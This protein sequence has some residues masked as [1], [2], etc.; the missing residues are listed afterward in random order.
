MD[1][2]VASLDGRTSGSSG[3]FEGLF[4]MDIA[5]ANA[6]SAS[7]K[8]AVFVLLRVPERVFELV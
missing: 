6:A 4:R 2:A 7:E 8:D 3:L 1:V 5:F